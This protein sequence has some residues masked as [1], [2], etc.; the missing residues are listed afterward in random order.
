MPVRRGEERFDLDEPISIFAASG[1]LSTGRIKDI[2]LSGVAIIADESRALATKLGQPVNLFIGQV[3]FVSATVVRQVGQ[4]LALRFNLPPCVERDLLIRKLFTA[5]L[6]ATA[7]S[8]SAWSS[9]GA[10]LLSIWSTGTMEPK[11]EPSAP[12]VAI[13]EK[14]PAESVVIL[15]HPAPQRLADLAAKRSIAA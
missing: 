7:V 5:G 12:L 2:S 4:I 3:G 6:D 10:T 11:V 8:A 14:L 9:T 15:A 13:F 1:A